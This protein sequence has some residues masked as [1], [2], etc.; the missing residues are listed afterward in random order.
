[1][2][3]FSDNKLKLGTFGAN[4]S[5]GCAATLAEGHLELNWPNTRRIVAT[6][7]AAGFEIHVP[8]ARWKGFGGESNF[9]GSSFETLTWASGLA[10]VTNSSTVFSTTHVPT[11]H[12]IV[13][14]KQCSTADHISGGRFGLNIVCGWFADEFKMFGSPMMDHEERYKYAAE[15]IEVVKKLWTVEEEFD[16]EGKYFKIDGGFHQPKPLQKPHPPIMNAGSSPTGAR[17]A[18]QY[19]DVAFFALRD[20]VV[21]ANAPN[22]EALRK[23]GRDEF[24]REFQV[25]GNCWV[26]CRPTEKEAK[27]YADYFIY[28]KGDWTAADNLVAQLGIAHAHLSQEVLDRVKYRFLAGWGGLPLIG[29][30]EQIVSKLI[31]MSA[32]GIDGVVLSW[33]DYDRDLQVWIDD[34]MPLMTEAGLRLPP[35]VKDAGSPAP[36]V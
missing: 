31:D 4:V 35:A 14:A 8:V 10:A 12:P 32:I 17:F 26:V 9:N 29:T 16:F 36:R 20:E 25:W 28:E 3:L 2:A 15:W 34:V 21:A 22:I 33:V 13:A 30:P 18:A 19:A 23:I 27:A 6:A 11:L 5:N 1:M 7:D 24:N